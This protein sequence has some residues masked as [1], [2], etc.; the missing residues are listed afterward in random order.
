[1]QVVTTEGEVADYRIWIVVGLLADSDRGGRSELGTK[2]IVIE[3]DR[4][5]KITPLDTRRRLGKLAREV[6]VN[7]RI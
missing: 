3:C 6:A 7:W 2:P 5:R 4:S 1:M